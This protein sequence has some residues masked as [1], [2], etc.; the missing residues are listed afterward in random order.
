MAKHKLFL[1][2]LVYF[3]LVVFAVLAGCFF[4]IIP[5]IL[6]HDRS[7]LTYAIAVFYVLTELYLGMQS[8]RISKELHLVHQGVDI[9]SAQNLS[10]IKDDGDAIV[11]KYGD[12]EEHLEHSFLVNHIHNLLRRRAMNRVDQ[13]ALLNLA[14]DQAF[15]RSERGL[16]MADIIT[17]LGLLGTMV[18][19]IIAFFPFFEGDFDITRG[20]LILTHLFN[21]ISVAFFTTATAIACSI[22][23]RVNSKHLE[24]GLQEMID[25]ITVISETSIIPVIERMRGDAGQPSPVGAAE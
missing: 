6:K 22:L 14:A 25:G 12:V 21:G 16:F 1:R 10:S 20:Q 8:F 15:S 3:V 13:Q 17:L 24:A 9:L 23:I 11:I 7:Y 18:G 4:D 2:W 5:F 19:L